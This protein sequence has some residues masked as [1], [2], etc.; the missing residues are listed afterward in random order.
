MT[1]DALVIFTPS[2]KRGRFAFAQVR[3]GTQ[4]LS[5]SPE[6]IPLPWGEGPQSRTTVDVPL[7]GE[8]MAP[9]GVVRSNN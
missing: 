9:L 6:S 2:G 5:L 8:A 4:R 7:R 3:T 1:D